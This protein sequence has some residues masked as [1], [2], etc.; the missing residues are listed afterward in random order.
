MKFVLLSLV[1]GAVPAL[2]SNYKGDAPP[3]GA[4]DGT[5]MTTDR[6]MSNR[7]NMPNGIC[8]SWIDS[9]TNDATYR[10]TWLNEMV[11]YHSQVDTA[12]SNA[13]KVRARVA[14]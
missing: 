1:F 3:L 5:C 8:H 11:F 6:A 12:T 13:M 9:D 7:C 10:A 4:G 2:A 14:E